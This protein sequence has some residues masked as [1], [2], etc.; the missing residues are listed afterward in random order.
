MSLGHESA[1][2]V[3]VVGSSVTDFQ[4]GDRVALEVGLACGIC[5]LCLAGK[6]N[7][8]REMKFRGSAKVFPHFQGTLQERIN[9]P[10]NLCYKL[11][12]ILTTAYSL[13]DC[14]K[15]FSSTVANQQ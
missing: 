3:E 10:A 7:L 1:G 9:H 4:P 2:V 13:G 14:L 6:Y 8:C 15:A 12:Q 5:K 11:V